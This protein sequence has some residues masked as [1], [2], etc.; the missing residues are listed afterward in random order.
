[1]PF[2]SGIEF[3]MVRGALSELPLDDEQAQQLNDLDQLALDLVITM[4]LDDVWPGLLEDHPDIPLER[5]WWHLGAIR[6]REYPTEFLPEHLQA[7]YRAALSR[8]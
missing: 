3:P 4:D 1:M 5:W 2:G 8:R 7:D 6:R